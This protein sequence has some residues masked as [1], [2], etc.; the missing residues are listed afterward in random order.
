M[1]NEMNLKS[2]FKSYKDIQN[3]NQGNLSPR[4]L[5]RE[6]TSSKVPELLKDLDNKNS[7]I[8]S[9][10]RK[11]KDL[12]KQKNEMLCDLEK[13]ENDFHIFERKYISKENELNDKIK[14]LE[15]EV[16]I[17]IIIIIIIIKIKKNLN[18]NLN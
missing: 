5:Y 8:I 7:E 4:I 10:N 1:G 3:Q 11:I 12:E 9:L 16:R 17:I 18:L 2:S 6:E 13:Y 15:M 14:I